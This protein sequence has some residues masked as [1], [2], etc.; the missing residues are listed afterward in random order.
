MSFQSFRKPQLAVFLALA[1]VSLFGARCSGLD[2][3]AYLELHEAGVDKYLGQF[4]PAST[5]EIEDGWTKHTFDPEEGDGP[6]CISGTE[7]SAFTREGDPEK[8]LIFEQGGGACWQDFYFCNAFAE[9]QEPPAPP[10]GI[11]DF[12]NPDNPF[13]DYS[14]VYMP[15]CDGSVFSG[16]NDVEDANYPLG[17]V[18]Y[19]RGL[20]NQSAAMDLAHDLFPE[21]KKI[22]LSGSSAGGVGVDGFAPFLVRFL[23]GDR[24]NL[25]VLNDAGPIT[26]NLAATEAIAARAE[27]WQFGQFY[28]E[29]CEDCDALGKATAIID[30]RL[31]RDRTIREG[32][33]ETDGD[34]TNRFFLGVPTQEEYRALI[35]E[36]TD[37]LRARHP[38]RFKRFIVSGDD[39]HTAVQTPL[40]YSQEV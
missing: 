1:S 17:P 8:L 36:Q 35:L 23:F 2:L 15:Y 27:D 13:A 29:S 5:S 39:S 38:F 28:P 34:G 16:D 33:Y 14:V 24:A 19:H 6:I 37:E 20:R 18:R 7:F 9:D 3:W 12:D 25:S 26:V 40:F 11:W 30:W 31:K 22:T 10:V 4:E 32:W 21:A